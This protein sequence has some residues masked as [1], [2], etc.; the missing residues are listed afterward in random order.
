[1]GCSGSGSG[2]DLFYTLSVP[3]GHDVMLR[4]SHTVQYF[5]LLMYVLRG[6]CPV[7]GDSCLSEGSSDLLVKIDD[8]PDGE[9]RFTNS[10]S[11]TASYYVVIDATY[12]G[13]G[14]DVDLR[15]I[16]SP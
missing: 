15:W 5:P 1:V 12:G 6:D 14:E 9:L 13:Y 11:A 16:V 7:R 2:G 8:A 3:A 4:A 10:S